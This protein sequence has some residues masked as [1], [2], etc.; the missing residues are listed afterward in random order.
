[1]MTPPKKDPK[2]IPFTVLRAELIKELSGLITETARQQAI[3]V[4]ET[5]RTIQHLR[6]LHDYVM[7]I[8]KSVS[9]DA[10]KAKG[11]IIRFPAPPCLTKAPRFPS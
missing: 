3:L 8:S 5:A 11:R 6:E 10:C 4:S 1:M 7:Q 9:G 2:P